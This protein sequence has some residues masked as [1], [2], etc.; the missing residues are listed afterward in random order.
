MKPNGSSDDAGASYGSFF[1]DE[2]RKQLASIFDIY[3]V[4]DEREVVHKIF[5]Y[6]NTYIDKPFDR[7]PK[8][9]QALSQTYEH[10]VH[11]F[12]SKCGVCRHQAIIMQILLKAFGIKAEFNVNHT[13][14]YVTLQ[15]NTILDVRYFDSSIKQKQYNLLGKSVSEAILL[16]KQHQSTDQSTDQLANHGS[17]FF[18][19]NM[20][21]VDSSILDLDLKIFN[22][23]KYLNNPHETSSEEL[24]KIRTEIKTKITEIKNPSEMVQGSRAIPLFSW[25]CF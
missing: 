8:M 17:G 1:L 12:I 3:D 25:H 22:A 4:N 11:S 13:H 9:S 10:L 5:H 19:D 21:P 2:E 20:G 7:K 6:F 14:A 23:Q 18:L 15:D 24:V 16:S